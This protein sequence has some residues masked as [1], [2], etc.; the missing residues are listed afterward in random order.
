[1]TE[2]D[3]RRLYWLH[4]LEATLP[5]ARLDLL[6]WLEVAGF[7]PQSTTQTASAADVDVDEDEDEEA[8][9]PPMPAQSIEVFKNYV[10]QLMLYTGDKL[11]STIFCCLY[12]R[13]R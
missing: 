6:E 1:M 4:R 10:T 8:V 2:D 13:H 9:A 5:V 11:S 3:W 7:R 12:V